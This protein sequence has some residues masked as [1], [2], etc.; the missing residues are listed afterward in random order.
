MNKYTRPRGDKCNLASARCLRVNMF[1]KIFVQNDEHKKID[2]CARKC[3]NH[4]Q[5]ETRKEVK[6]N[7]KHH[8]LQIYD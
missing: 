3:Y 2:N 5:K 6:K 1:W 8:S 7:E 4:R